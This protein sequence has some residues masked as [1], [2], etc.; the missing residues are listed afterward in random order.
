MVALAQNIGPLAT[1]NEKGASV[2]VLT[3]FQ[4]RLDG[5][6]LMKLSLKSPPHLNRVAT[7]P[8]EIRDSSAV[9]LALTNRR[10]FL[11]QPI[12]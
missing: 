2:H 12:T 5:E 8:C 4:L 9:W 3:D 10:V 11:R 1:V 7:L 6:Y